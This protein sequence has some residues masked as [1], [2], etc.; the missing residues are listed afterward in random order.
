MRPVEPGVFEADL[1]GLHRLRRRIALES[2]TTAWK[3]RMFQHCDALIREVSDIV[4][5]KAIGDTKSARS[6]QKRSRKPS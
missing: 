6:P 4:T 1:A 5:K 2:G 3:A